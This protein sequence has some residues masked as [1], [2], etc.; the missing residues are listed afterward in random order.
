MRKRATGIFSEP[1]VD[2]LYK[3]EFPV[4][5]GSRVFSVEFLPGQFDQ[6]ADSASSVR[7][8]YQRG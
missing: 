5:D 8:V 2:I 4:K 7:A 3:E 1:P 6:R